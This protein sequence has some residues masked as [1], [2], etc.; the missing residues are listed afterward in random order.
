LYKPSK[1]RISEADTK[2]T[3]PLTKSPPSQTRYHNLAQAKQS[4]IHPHTAKHQRTRKANYEK[5]I[6][7]YTPATSHFIQTQPHPI[8][9]QPNYHQA[10]WRQINLVT[11]AG[12]FGTTTQV[13]SEKLTSVSSS[14]RLRFFKTENMNCSTCCSVTLGWL[15]LSAN[16][17]ASAVNHQHILS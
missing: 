7:S 6:S 8:H 4:A 15:I 16:P 17:P 13:T 5:A 9:T 11:F 1:P 14:N 12:I 3:N 10:R 2:T